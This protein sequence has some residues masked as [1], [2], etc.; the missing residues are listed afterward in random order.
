MFIQQL[1]GI[2]PSQILRQPVYYLLEPETIAHPL[3][4]NLDLHQDQ[5]KKANQK[6]ISL[7][8]FALWEC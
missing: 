2:M 3:G 8:V 7:V 4:K 5:A 6:K 1:D